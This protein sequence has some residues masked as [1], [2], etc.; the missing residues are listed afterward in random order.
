MSQSEC[1]VCYQEFPKNETNVV[2]PECGHKFHYTCLFTWNKENPS[3]PLCR[4]N[5]QHIESSPLMNRQLPTEWS[6]AD[7]F[8]ESAEE[9]GMMLICRECNHKVESCANGCGRTTCFCHEGDSN[10]LY[11]T[12]R[13]PIQQQNTDYPTCVECWRQRYPIVYDYLDQQST[14]DLQTDEAYDTE[15]M[16]EYYEMFFSNTNG[17][18]VSEDGNPN[19]LFDSTFIDYYDFVEH[20]QDS[21]QT[22][23]REQFANNNIM[24][25][26][27]PVMNDEETDIDEPEEILSIGV[28]YHEGK[29]FYVDEDNDVMSQD[30]YVVGKYIM[31]NDGYTIKFN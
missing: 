16:E 6:M 29:E 13:S 23:S 20:I 30:G 31:E 4:K 1:P 5:F 18:Y 22:H 7:D 15:Q 24:D 11:I 21:Y 25:T 28:I 27:T 10:N 17:N 19:G 8:I 26:S 14:R 3:C 9:F 2:T 12:N